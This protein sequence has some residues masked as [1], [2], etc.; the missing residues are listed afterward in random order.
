MLNN[1]DIVFTIWPNSDRFLILA[2]DYMRSAISGVGKQG[3]AGYIEAQ[4][5][6]MVT[7]S[8]NYRIKVHE[9][10]LYCTV[11]DVVQSL[12]NAIAKQ[13]EVSPAKYPVRK[14]EMRNLFLTES[15]TNVSWNVFQSTIPRRLLVFFVE[16]NS[17]DGHPE[18]S[19]FNFNHSFVESICVEANN[20]VVPSVPYRLDF[21]NLTNA[22]FVRAFFDLYSGLDLQDRETAIELTLKKFTNGWAV[23]AFP[24]SSF[25][26]DIGDSFELIRNGT[27]V[28]KANFSKPIEA[29]G[30]QMITLAEFDQII[31]I[32]SDRV[33]ST[34]GSI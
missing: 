1:T 2:P 28:I 5:S 11:V 20:I 12:Q 29:P 9:V 30:L 8:T 19:P 26:K 18:K 15:R 21:G 4:P 6:Q 16:N 32:N 17:F 10:K 7:N 23:W 25:Q 31:T 24:L 3:E 14:I 27:T 34:D 22:N 33:L 13:L